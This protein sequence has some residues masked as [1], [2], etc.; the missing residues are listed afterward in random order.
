[1]RQIDLDPRLKHKRRAEQEKAEQQQDNI[2]HRHEI[3]Q[4][5]QRLQP[6]GKHEGHRDKIKEEGRSEKVEVNG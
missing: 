6:A 1:M 5:A 4:A 3:D 2:D